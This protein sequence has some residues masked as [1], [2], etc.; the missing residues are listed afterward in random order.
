MLKRLAVFV[1]LVLTGAG[2]V[3]GCSSQPSGPRPSSFAVSYMGTNYCPY[4]YSAYEINMY[5]VNTSTCTPMAFPSVS[6]TPAMGTID[7]ALWQYRLTYADFYDSGYWY[8]TYYYPIGSRYHVSIVSR[9]SYMSMS[10]TFNKTYAPQIK[11]Y[12]SK[13]KW[14]SGQSGRY[15]FPASNAKAYS[16]ANKNSSGNKTTSNT[17]FSNT[18]SGSNYYGN[19]SRSDSGFSNSG[20]SSG[21]GISSG[22]S[23][24]R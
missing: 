23:G 2:L 12:S 8:D 20:R 11:T 14:S 1:A 22:K 7:Y 17:G 19:S 5:G 15:T 3:A 9:T 18:K 24:R 16:A 10:S 13:A 4:V 21:G 6:M